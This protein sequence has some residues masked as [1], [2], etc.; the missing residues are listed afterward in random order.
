MGPAFESQP[1]YKKIQ[2]SF[3]FKKFDTIFEINLVF[4][5][6]VKFVRNIWNVNTVVETF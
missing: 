6:L 1:G 3:E 2:I 5:I 4:D